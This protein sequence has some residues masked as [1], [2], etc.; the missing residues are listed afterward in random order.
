M[1]GH[2]KEKEKEKE[3]GLSAAII[4]LFLLSLSLLL[5]TWVQ[6]T[7]RKEGR[8]GVFFVSAHII[9]QLSS[10]FVPFLPLLLLLLY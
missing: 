10:S 6:T 5:I 9:M 2:L 8:K 1:I 3:G 4:R 7:K